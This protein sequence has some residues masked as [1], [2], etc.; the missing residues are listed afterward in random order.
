MILPK[1][2]VIS[3]SIK[4]YANEIDEESKKG[5]N[6]FKINIGN[7]AIWRLLESW[8]PTIIQIV[9]DNRDR[10]AF[11]EFYPNELD[12]EPV[13]DGIFFRKDSPDAE[14]FSSTLHRDTNMNTVNIELND[15]YE[16]GGL[17]YMKPLA[18][19]GKINPS[20]N[21][22]EWVD[23]VKR[24][25]TSDIIFP[26]LQ[27]GDAILY[28][29]TVDH[30]TAL[31]ES[32]SRYSMAFLFDMDNP[33]LRE[34]SGKEILEIELQSMLHGLELDIVLVYDALHEKHVSKVLFDKITPDVTVTC[35][36]YEGD[37]LHA[38]V[39]GTDKLVSEIE[40]GPYKSYYKI[41]DEPEDPDE[42]RV[43]L[44]NDLPDIVLD[45]VLVYDAAE[46]RNVWKTKFDNVFFDEEVFYFAYEGDVLRALVAG[47][48]TVVS[49][50]EIRL[51]QSLY[52]I[53][54]IELESSEL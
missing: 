2:N 36:A 47:T 38:L 15:D 24:E 17:F 23:S 1:K 13:L 37:K 45:I 31:V 33:A 49:D 12:R 3:Q 21:G 50:I 19:T 7:E 39:A 6:K 35:E 9:K 4:V 29:Y 40:I 52:V 11:G 46:E 51:D 16:G 43:K 26:S 5:D 48:D 42:F 22:Y 54:Q 20:Y 32:G 34:D 53:S 41:S 14:R 18:N 25:N 8:I 44:H 28:N 27:V 10:E 30:A